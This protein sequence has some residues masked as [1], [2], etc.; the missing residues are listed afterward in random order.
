M[1]LLLVDDEDNIRRFLAK[2]LKSGGFEVIEF[3]NSPD[4]LAW[5]ESNDIEVLVTDVTLNDI[6]GSALARAIIKRNPEL[7]VV[8]ISG[9]PFDI[10]AERQSHSYCAYMEKPFPPRVLLR[11]ISELDEQRQRHHT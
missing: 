3:T 1:R 7:L 8:F 6:D 9:F 2:I 10:E 11:T 5:S 4:A